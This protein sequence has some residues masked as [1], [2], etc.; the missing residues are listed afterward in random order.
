MVY[1]RLS[2]VG[3]FAGRAILNEVQFRLNAMVNHGGFPAYPMDL[4][5][6]QDDDSAR[7]IGPTAEATGSGAG[8]D[9]ARGG[10]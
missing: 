4:F 6:W 3:R 2:A 9:A 7:P 5:M 10:E 8:G 1:H